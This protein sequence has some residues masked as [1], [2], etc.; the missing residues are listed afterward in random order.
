MSIAGRFEYKTTEYIWFR[1]LSKESHI[2]RFG[3]VENR[4]INGHIEHIGG[5]SPISIDILN[6]VRLIIYLSH[7]DEN[8]LGEIKSNLENPVNRLEVIHFGRAEDWVVFEEISDIF[9]ITEFPYKQFD[10]DFKNFFW[11]PENIYTSAYHQSNTFDR[12]SGLIYNLP[13]FCSVQDFD[14]TYNRHGQRIFQH[15][16][17]KLNDGLFVNQ[18]FLFD[19]ELGLPVFLAEL[20]E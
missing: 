5:Q 4:F 20:N 17:V 2:N 18:S 7:N 3:Y 14:K 8:F 19:K 6:D 11:I 13:T 15:I 10:A 1:N 16:K 12:I 9:D